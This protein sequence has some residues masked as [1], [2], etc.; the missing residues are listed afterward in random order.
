MESKIREISERYIDEI[1]KMGSLEEI[2][3]F[4]ISINGSTLNLNIT[5]EEEIEIS[6][7]VKKYKI[8]ILIYKLFYACKEFYQNSFIP[9]KKRIISFYIQYNKKYYKISGTQKISLDVSFEEIDKNKIKQNKILEIENNK[10]NI[11][12]DEKDNFDMVIEYIYKLHKNGFKEKEIINLV[13]MAT[14]NKILEENSINK[15]KM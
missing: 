1:Y 10:I 7:N 8:Q 14:K 5:N 4:L 15:N 13:K 6:E 3:K 11:Y 9:S 12:I 2:L